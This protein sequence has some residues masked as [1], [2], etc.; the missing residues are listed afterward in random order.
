M[1]NP[2]RFLP[3]FFLSGYCLIATVAA[4]QFGDFTYQ[5][6]GTSIGISDYPSDATGPVVV[7]SV[8]DGKPVQSLFSNAFANCS[9]I[10]RVTLPS[11]VTSLGGQTFFGCTQMTAIDIA[12]NVTALDFSLFQGC[13]SLARIKLP[14]QLDSVETSTFQDCTS[15]AR[16]SF[17]ATVTSLG[18][19][20]FKGCS[21]LTEVAFRGNA[22]TLGT[23]VFLSTAPGFTVK[24]YNGATGFTTPTW[25]GYSSVN[26]GD[27]PFP[28]ISVQQ[29]A[30][31]E[32]ADGGAG[33]DL[34]SVVLGLPR[35]FNFTIV[36]SGGEDLIDLA[37]TKDG[38]NAGEFTVTGPANDFVP[39]GGS[40]TFTVTFDPSA[41]GV[42]TAALHIASDD[43][44]ESPYDIVLTGTGIPVPKPEIEVMQPESSK[45][46]DGKAKKSFGTVVVGK[47]G[48]PKKFT[49]K[50]TG[51]ANL[52]G[53]SVSVS[54]GNADDFVI[55]KPGK[56]SLGHDASTF[57]KVT[58]KPTAKG[59]RSA[60]LKI[61]SNDGDE[62]PFDIKLSG[63]G[64]KK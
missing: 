30:G 2:P 8:I 3:R 50:N 35:A 63:M 17:P 11:S 45:L 41:L 15:L 14:G 56:T 54:G 53:I 31:A 44:D 52:T 57:F 25:N 58:F 13:S 4:A 46:V 22:P 6:F 62:N 27:L 60:T 40:A 1:K 64:A 55:T 16:V 34:G 36:N 39:A 37:I 61:K 26:A 9:Q 47:K 7:P 29:P 20:S 42:R 10:T 43:A 48:A 59:N 12:G 21:A 38:A 49:I 19:N 23:N 24:F 33:K 18:N 51:A 28:E 5:D 32:L